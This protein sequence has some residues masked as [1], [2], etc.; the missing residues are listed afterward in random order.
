MA[1]IATAATKF[2]SG[3]YQL[4]VF[5]EAGH[6]IQEDQPTKTAQVVADFYKRNDRTGLIL[7]PKVDDLIKQGK[8]KPA[9][10]NKA[11]AAHL[12]GD[13]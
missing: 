3:K 10:Q 4:Q 13:E 5:P 9:V 7:P 1:P 8:L 6:F 2:Q 11:S 12:R